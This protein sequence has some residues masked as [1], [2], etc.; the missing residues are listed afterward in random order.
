MQ[1][2]AH[3]EHIGHP[4]SAVV[5]RVRL[6]VLFTGTVLVLAALV[7]DFVYSSAPRAAEF[8]AAIGAVLLAMPVFW[9]AL[10]DLAT[11]SAHMAELVALKG[12]LKSETLVTL[13]GY[14][15]HDL[16]SMLSMW[17]KGIE[18]HYP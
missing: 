5:Q 17:S 10:R 2:A 11:G 15:R 7:S 9:A 12:I 6:Q 16:D 4:E 13:R 18:F 14:S 1:T 3:G 8:A